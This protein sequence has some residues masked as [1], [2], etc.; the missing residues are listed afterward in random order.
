MASLLMMK[1]D[2]STPT[3]VNLALS[4]TICVISIVNI[5][6]V[7]N[8]VKDPV[9]QQN[10]SQKNIVNISKMLLAVGLLMLLASVLK[11]AKVM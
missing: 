4:F 1:M 3:L 9:D 2:L 8:V 5:A 6:S 10:A 11:V 7:N